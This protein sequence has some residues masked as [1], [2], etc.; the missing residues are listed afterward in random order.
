MRKPD[1]PPS[2]A[3]KRSS[4]ARISIVETSTDPEPPAKVLKR[5]KSRPRLSSEEPED[6]D[7]Y[8]EGAQADEEYLP[9]KNW[10]STGRRRSAYVSTGRRSGNVGEDERRHSTAI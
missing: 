3:P 1:P 6:E 5:R 4:I 2:S 8:D 7:D 10:V 9:Q